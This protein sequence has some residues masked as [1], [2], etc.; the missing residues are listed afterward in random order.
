MI[1]LARRTGAA[2]TITE[3]NNKLMQTVKKRCV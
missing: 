1:R 2:Q 3:D